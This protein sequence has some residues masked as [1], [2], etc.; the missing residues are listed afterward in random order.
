VLD[1]LL[2]RHR[3]TEAAKCFFE[4]LLGEHEV[5]DTVCTDKLASDAAAIRELP[6]LEVVDHRQ[7]IS[8]AV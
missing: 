5:P 3:D 6:A 1:V 7:E 8:S 2:Q 4:R